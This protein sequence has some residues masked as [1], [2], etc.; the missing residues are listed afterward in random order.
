MLNKSENTIGLGRTFTRSY[1]KNMVVL[2]S[3][4]RVFFSRPD[5]Y[6][7]AVKWQRA[8]AAQLGKS[9]CVFWGD[10]EGCFQ[11]AAK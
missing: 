3:E 2:K 11:Q 9:G 1:L 7:G 4:V 5:Q 8:P 6:G 10:T